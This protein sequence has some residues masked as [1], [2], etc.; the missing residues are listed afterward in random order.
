MLKKAD[1]QKRKRQQNRDFTLFFLIAGGLGNLP[2]SLTKC[3]PVDTIFMVCSEQ[4]YGTDW[5][6]ATVRF[7]ILLGRWRVAK[8]V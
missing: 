4:A 3:K 8:I 6:L 5:L 7:V 1:A 2:I